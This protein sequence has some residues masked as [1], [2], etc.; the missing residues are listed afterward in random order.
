MYNSHH[1]ETLRYAQGDMDAR[2]LGQDLKGDKVGFS[3]KRVAGIS[4]P[5][6]N[7]CVSV[8]IYWYIEKAVSSRV[9]ISRRA[10]CPESTAFLA[11]WSAGIISSGF[12]T[13]S[14]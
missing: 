12:S 10:A 4:Q 6:V 8:K 13:F 14:E 3:K 1:P 11:L 9:M 5:P 2:L 7:N